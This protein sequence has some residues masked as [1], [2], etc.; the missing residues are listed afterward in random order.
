MLTVN[1]VL[2]VAKAFAPLTVAAGTD[3][4][5]TITLT[6][7]AG[8]V[9]LSGLAFTDTLPAGHLVSAT[10]NLVNNCGGAVTAT[11]GTNTITLAGGALAVGAGATSCTILVNVTTPAGAGAG[12][13]HDR[14]GRGELGAGIRQPGGSERDRHARGHQRDAQQVVQP[15]DGAGRR[16]VAAD[17]QHHQHQRQRDRVDGTAL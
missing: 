8:A 14:G 5:A 1:P 13:E 3:T 6:R 11:S 17:D 12:D 7:A 9:A 2:S 4:R 15:G 10:P 16:H